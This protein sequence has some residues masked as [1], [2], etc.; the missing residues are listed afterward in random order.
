MTDNPLMRPMTT[1]LDQSVRA[2]TWLQGADQYAAGCP[3]PVSW[4]DRLTMSWRVARWPT[5]RSSSNST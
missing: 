3:W 5:P 1:V 2:A 4:P